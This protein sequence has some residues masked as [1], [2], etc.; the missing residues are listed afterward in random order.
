[1]AAYPLEALRTLRADEEESARRALADAVRACDDAATLTT[2]ARTRRTSHEDETKALL[3]RESARP[4]DA[5]RASD[6]T[7][8]RAWRARRRDELTPLDAALAQA[9]RH[10]RACERAVESAREVLAGTRRER[11]A[12]EKH[13]ARWADDARRKAEAKEEAEAEDRRR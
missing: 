4:L 3:A 9:E 1:M 10:E 13:H 8:L 11:E 2:Q 12:I 7:Q 5:V 6:A